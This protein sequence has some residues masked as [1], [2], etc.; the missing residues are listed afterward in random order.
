MKEAMTSLVT[1]QTNASSAMLDQLS[2]GEIIQLMNQED[3]T[4]AHSVQHQLPSIERTIEAIAERMA[5]G[6]RL[7]YIG[8]G[9]SGRLG[10]LDAS[11]C[12]PTFGVDRSLVNAIIAGGPDALVQAIENAED[13]ADAG[14]RDI[15]ARVTDKD[16]VVGLATSGTTPYVLGAVAEAKRIGAVTAA[17]S[18]NQG[19]PLSAA[20]DYPIEIPVGPEVISGSTRLKAGTSQ[21]M[22]LNMISSAVMI[23]M[24]KVYG[25]L[26]V[27]VQASNEKLR[28]RVVRI[29]MQA[30]G[31]DEGAALRYSEQAGGDARIAILMLKFGQSR[32]DVEAV[33]GRTNGHFRQAVELL[34]GM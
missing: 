13:D 27:N 19:T 11:E 26:M 6:G 17:I 12:P 15:A 14:R 25:N 29:V 24:G 2:V 3:L 5:A 28:Q 20:V 30:T 31:A 18:C 32:A 23:R 8:A 4:V 1:E 33:L 10:T 21:K 7:F 34:E 9:T 16:A 22:V